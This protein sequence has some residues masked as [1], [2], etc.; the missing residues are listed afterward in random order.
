MLYIF[1]DESGNFDFS[2]SGTSYYIFSALSSTR[3]FPSVIPLLN[4]KYD[5]WENG[6]EIEYF[7]ATEDRQVV[8]DDV[9]NII[10]SDL[11]NYRID[12]IIIEKRK[13][14]P[15]LQNDKKRFYKK[16]FEILIKYVL[17]GQRNSFN[18]IKIVCDSIP[19]R[20]NR[21]R[22]EK[23]VKTALSSWAK[24]HNNSY[25]LQYCSSKSDLNL[26]IVDYINWA[27]YRKWENQD[28]RSYDLIQ[29]CIQSE[30]DVFENGTEYFY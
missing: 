10:T 28:N 27:I 25:S 19:I 2:S 17:E 11:T 21:K 18:N 13:T 3:P 22:L 9:F 26:Q 4:L 16:F 7:H 30:F 1:L 20:Q 6:L 5:L 24:L 23:A 8:R 29:S 12:S 14:H 15:V